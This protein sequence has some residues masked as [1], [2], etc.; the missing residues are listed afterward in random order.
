MFFFLYGHLLFFVFELLLGLPWTTSRHHGYRP[1]LFSFM[2]SRRV[3]YV[4]FLYM[5]LAS[6]SSSWASTTTP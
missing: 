4:V 5:V 3:L 6:T 2:H 1:Q